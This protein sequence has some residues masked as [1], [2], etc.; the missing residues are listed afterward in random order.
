MKPFPQISAGN[1]MPIAL[2]AATSIQGPFKYRLKFSISSMKYNES[3]CIF[4]QQLLRQ[5]TDD[6]FFFEKI[7]WSFKYLPPLDSTSLG[8]TTFLVQ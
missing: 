2:P 4:M 5:I 6:F 7:L 8:S 1:N 3:C